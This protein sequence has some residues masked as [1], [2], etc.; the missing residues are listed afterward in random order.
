[1]LEAH[2]GVVEAAVFGRPH[3]QWGEIVCAWVVTA[4]GTQI[5]W[6]ELAAQCR[7]QLAAYKVPK[8]FHAS[9]EP[10][11]RTASGKLLRRELA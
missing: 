3:E 6:D 2:P 8:A 10:L 11:P 4:P 9:N 7:R 5:D 1:V